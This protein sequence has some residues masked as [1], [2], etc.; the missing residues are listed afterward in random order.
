MM[1]ILDVSTMQTPIG[2]LTVVMADG[3]TRTVKRPSFENAPS[4]R[5]R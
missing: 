1:R 2:P 5:R 4:P 3:T